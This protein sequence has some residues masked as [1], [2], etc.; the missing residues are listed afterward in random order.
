MKFD[1]SMASGYIDS[2][3][4]VEKLASKSIAARYQLRNKQYPQEY[5]IFV[6]EYERI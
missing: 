2:I 1:T 3:P 4:P 5:R 6:N